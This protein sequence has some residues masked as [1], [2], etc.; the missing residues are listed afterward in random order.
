[1]KSSEPSVAAAVGASAN[2]NASSALTQSPP[3][4]EL[5]SRSGRK[6]KPKKFLDEETFEGGPGVVPETN[7]M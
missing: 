5:V 6:I 4:Q 2:S 7:G 3:K 1:V